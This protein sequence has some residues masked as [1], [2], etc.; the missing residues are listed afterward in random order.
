MKTS[1]LKKKSVIAFIVLFSLLLCF[2]L[3]V[4]YKH[5]ANS[6]P[7]EIPPLISASSDIKKEKKNSK[8]DVKI[9]THTDRI[10]RKPDKAVSDN[11]KVIVNKKDASISKESAKK[12][13]SSD[14]E[15]IASP[16]LP[17]KLLLPL[18][19]V[20]L[21][22]R[23]FSTLCKDD[24]KTLDYINRKRLAAGLKKLPILPT[25]LNNQECLQLLNGQL[26]EEGKEPLSAMP[27]GLILKKDL[28]KDLKKGD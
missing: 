1:Y 3:W 19:Q 10:D 4:K 5:H 25:G 9:I 8:Q 6:S 27:T 23:K 11:P 17:E 24:L 12:G 13:K 21:S 28:K 7:E 26:I 16:S 20:K 2:G 15:E 14:A 22:K 18:Q